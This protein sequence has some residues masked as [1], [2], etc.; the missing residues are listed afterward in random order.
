MGV[1]VSWTAIRSQ[2]FWA[3]R[4]GQ[5]EGLVKIRE[6]MRLYAGYGVP[7]GVHGA[8]REDLGHEILWATVDSAWGMVNYQGPLA[9]DSICIQEREL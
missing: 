8:S 4:G 7:Y 6:A 9:S 2:N 5:L 1:G 3:R